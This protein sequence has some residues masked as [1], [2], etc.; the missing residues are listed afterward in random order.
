MFTVK[1]LITKWGLYSGLT[2]SLLLVQ[3]LVLDG[4]H[5][6]GVVP[7]LAPMIVAVVAALEGS[8]QGTIFGI[9]FGF[10]CDLLGGGLF[11][12]VYTL[13]FFCIALCVSLLA[14]VRVMPNLPGSLVYAAVA[15]VLLD[16]IQG[17]FLMLLQRADV[18]SVLSLGG[19]EL[20]VSIL[21]VLPVFWLFRYLHTLFRYD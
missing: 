8:T 16:A 14:S 13:S 3:N 20:L 11:P 4:L 15:F 19:R 2:L 10:L 12:G 1:A 21:F 18:V 6:F 9:S 17:A 7:F 5:L